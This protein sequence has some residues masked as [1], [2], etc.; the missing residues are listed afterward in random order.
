MNRRLGGLFGRSPFG[1]IHEHM[2]KVH[3]CVEHLVVLVEALGAG[4]WDE[5]RHQAKAVART[6]QE[7][8]AVKQSI[9]SCLTKSI[10]ASVARS[11]IMTLLRAQDAVADRCRDVGHLLTLRRVGVPDFLFEPFVEYVAQVQETVGGLAAVT[12]DLVRLA[13]DGDTGGDG[14]S[15]STAVDVVYQRYRRALELQEG[16]QARMFDGEHE[17]DEMTVVVLF[18]VVGRLG[19]MAA[20][21]ERASDAVRSWVGQASA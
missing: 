4:D 1:P 3:A 17:L 13:D 20:A 11:E 18:D 15:L 9:G 14:S 7:A 8:D 2:S 12:H 16:L 5:C 19:E 10:F 6:E 21:A